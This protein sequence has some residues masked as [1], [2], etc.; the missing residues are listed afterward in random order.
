M[1]DYTI[2]LKSIAQ[3]KYVQ[4]AQ[5]LRSVLGLKEQAA[6]QIVSSVPLALFEGL[7]RAQANAI[8]E[9]MAPL[10]Q[11]GAALGVTPQPGR[12]YARMSWPEPPSVAGRDLASFTSKQPPAG[13]RCPVCGAELALVPAGSP[14]PAQHAAAPAQPAAVEP[15]P[16]AVV[17]SGPAFEVTGEGDLQMLDEVEVGAGPGAGVPD[18]PD[19]PAATKSPSTQPATT[20][21]TVPMD[22][23][24]FEASFAGQAEEELGRDDVLQE[25]G[26]AQAKP[27]AGTQPQAPPA[28]PKP[29]AGAG[30]R[31]PAARP[32]TP[33]TKARRRASGS[34]RAGRKPA[35]GTPVG[36]G[37]GSMPSAGTGSFSVFAAKSNNRR[38][39]EF[40]AEVRGITV[41]AAKKLAKR[42]VV[43][44]A[45]DVSQEEAESIREV[46]EAEGFQ[47]RVHGKGG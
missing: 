27:V 19:V 23:E 4:V 39:L 16:S 31:A 44:L 8:L 26:E 6:G 40:V 34:R 28:Q 42:Q 35:T 36:S 41:Q 46:F 43:Q 20:K 3:G 13:L 18:V 14:A 24:D 11:A 9:A 21:S 15:G 30:A 22:L 29:E 37:S 17:E 32:K 38:F 5:A 12:A 10:Q 7:E 33:P 45:R 2:V 25:L 47:A 1:A